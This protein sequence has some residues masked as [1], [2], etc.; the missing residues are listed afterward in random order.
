VIEIEKILS[1]STTDNNIAMWGTL[2]VAR[3]GG[4]LVGWLIDSW[5]LSGVEPHLRP[6]MH[7]IPKEDGK[8]Y[9]VHL[10][11]GVR[12]SLTMGDED[13][14]IEPR[15]AAFITSTLSTWEKEWIEEQSKG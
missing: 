11:V 9:H 13:A 12:N 4:E 2:H 3:P 1:R 8:F 14:N 10:A 6:K 15:R 5:T 7:W